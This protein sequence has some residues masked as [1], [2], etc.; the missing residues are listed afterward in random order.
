MRIFRMS[1]AIIRD[2][3]AQVSRNARWIL[4]RWTRDIRPF[5]ALP[6]FIT[7]SYPSV[8]IDRFKP[9]Y[10]QFCALIGAHPDFSLARRF[11]TTRAR[12]LL[13]KQDEVYRLEHDLEQ[14]DA[15]EQ[16]PLFLGTFQAD[17]NETRRKVLKDLDRTLAE[18]DE[19]L[20]R[21]VRIL[22]LPKAS[23]RNIS[24]L[25]N[26]VT[27]TGNI[28][29]TDTKFLYEADL[30]AVGSHENYGMLWLESWAEIIAIKALRCF[31]KTSR[32]MNIFIFPGSILRAATCCLITTL[33]LLLLLGPVLAI[34]AVNIT[35]FQMLCISIAS[36]LFTMM[37]SG[38]MNAKPAEIFS[39]GAT[40]ASLLVAFL[41][42]R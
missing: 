20:E 3:E 40:Y 10:P 37:L 29:R 7:R 16:R 5:A 34:P 15:Q 6:Q 30:C 11:S 4:G 33:L 36:I 1:T 12:L 9:G 39:A 14:I 18:Y 32:S 25:R 42:I 13:M 8:D 35:V 19:L 41:T 17:R 22:Q 21:N 38:P 28:Y 26:W 23:E 24:N 31:G 2:I 27:G